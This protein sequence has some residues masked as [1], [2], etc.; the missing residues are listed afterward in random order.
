MVSLICL[1][2][3]VK[4]ELSSSV[5]MVTQDEI[6]CNDFRCKLIAV[7]QVAGIITVFVG[8]TVIATVLQGGIC[9]RFYLLHEL[10]S[11]GNL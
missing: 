8:I 3:E 6:L 11:F 7:S 9:L 4:Q 5:T 10:L 2:T 1:F